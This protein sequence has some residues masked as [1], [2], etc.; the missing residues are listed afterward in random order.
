MGKMNPE[1]KLDFKLETSF[2]KFGEFVFKEARPERRRAKE[3]K[4]EKGPILIYVLPKST[5]AIAEL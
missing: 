3:E 2:T 4:P 5:A 1:E